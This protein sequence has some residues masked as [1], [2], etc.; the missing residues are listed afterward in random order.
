MN[1]AFVYQQLASCP[2]SRGTVR[3]PWSGEEH[4]NP[5][6]S[7]S[8]GKW[9][10]SCLSVS[11]VLVKLPLLGSAPD[12]LAQ[13]SQRWRPTDLGGGGHPRRDMPFQRRPPFSCSKSSC[14]RVV[15]FK[16]GEMPVHT[17]SEGLAR[18]QGLETPVRQW[19]PLQILGQG[20][21]H[22]EEGGCGEWAGA[23]RAGARMALCAG[24]R[25]PSLRAGSLRLE[26]VG[27]SASRTGARRGASS[28]LSSQRSLRRERGRS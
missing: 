5:Q 25:D 20:N 11:W 13:T 28:Q 19:G 12:R 4:E 14:G 17:H 2:V 24:K 21:E 27:N 10:T 15:T 3:R 9:K 6:Q 8:Q 18:E 22:L 7:V 16:Q 1:F 23:C 26:P